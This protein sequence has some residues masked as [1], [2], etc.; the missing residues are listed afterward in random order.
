[1]MNVAV[2]G[3]LEVGVIVGTHGLRGDL[4]VKPLPTG[5]LALPG[6]REVSLRDSAG[7]LIS[8]RVVRSTLHKQN[9][10]LRLEG[11][12]SLVAVE[13]L[14]GVSVFMARAQLPKLPADQFYWTDIEDFEVVDQR[15]GTLGRVTGMFTTAAHDILEVEGLRGEILIP[16]IEPFLIECDREGNRLLVS[17]PD[18]LVPESGD[19]S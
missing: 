9:Y 2:Q 11:L 13:P 5:D 19:P 7:R 3:L 6:A 15:L 18:G 1:M 14:V 16:A 12:D 4:K 8:Y 17:L 10:L